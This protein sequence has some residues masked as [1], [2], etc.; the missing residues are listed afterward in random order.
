MFSIARKPWFC[1]AATVAL[2]LCAARASAQTTQLGPV[3]NVSLK[4]LPPGLNVKLEAHLRV[5]NDGESRIPAGTA[6]TQESSTTEFER[7]ETAQ[8]TILRPVVRTTYSG[9][10]QPSFFSFVRICDA[11]TAPGPHNLELHATVDGANAAD[12][13]QVKRALLLSTRIQ[14]GGS[15]F[16]RTVEGTSFNPQRGG[17]PGQ[18]APLGAIQRGVAELITVVHRNLFGEFVKPSL[19]FAPPFT[20]LVLPGST[21]RLFRDPSGKNCITARLKTL[22]SVNNNPVTHGGV[23]LR[24]IRS[25]GG[26]AV[27][28]N[29]EFSFTLTAGFAAGSYSLKAKAD[30]PDLD[31]YR[32]DGELQPL[33]LVTWR[34]NTT[35]VVVN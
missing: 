15:S 34:T 35:S 16:T 25:T 9:Q 27:S 6:S 12:E 10:I 13:P 14:D 31:S 23:E 28:S 4:G 33:N 8:G 24:S 29:F 30:D 7:V 21:T 32:V 20:G 3:Y 11:T 17:T 18:G 26:S 2:A 19:E 1:L 22:C 5:C